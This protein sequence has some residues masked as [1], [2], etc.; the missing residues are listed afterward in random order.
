MRTRT[1][2][3][4]TTGSRVQTFEPNAEIFLGSPWE[5]GITYHMTQV[6]RNGSGGP[7]PDDPT[8]F[9]DFGTML[10]SPRLGPVGWA[11]GRSTTAGLPI[12]ISGQEGCPIVG[13]LIP[14]V[15]N[16]RGPC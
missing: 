4:E 15:H 3:E 9:G 13:S 12:A 14:C 6:G 7:T 1:R 11:D 8:S 10:P 16:E 5:A 2:E